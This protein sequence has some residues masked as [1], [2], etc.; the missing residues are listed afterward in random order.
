MNNLNDIRIEVLLEIKIKMKNKT[1]RGLYKKGE[2]GISLS[3]EIVAHF[4]VDNLVRANY[5]TKKI[6]KG[7]RSEKRNLEKKREI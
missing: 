4:L 3:F 1:S 6:E 7:G 2:T 5:I